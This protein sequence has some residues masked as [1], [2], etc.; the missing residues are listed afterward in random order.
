[1]TPI[2]IR[3]ASQVV[4][5]SIG[6]EISKKLSILLKEDEVVKLVQMSQFQRK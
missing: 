3:K 6:A 2:L 4:V 1:M 5:G